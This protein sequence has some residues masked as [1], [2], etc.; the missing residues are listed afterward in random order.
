MCVYTSVSCVLVVLAAISLTHSFPTLDSVGSAEWRPPTSRVLR[1]PKTNS[2]YASAAAHLNKRRVEIHDLEK[3]LMINCTDPHALFFSECWDI[4]GI[5]DYLV[6]QDTGWINTVRYCGTVGD[7]WENDGATCCVKGEA[8][9]TCYLRLASPGSNFDCTSTSGGRCTDAMMSLI[10]V[11]P[12]I[13]PFVRYTV[14][15]IYAINNFFYTYYQALYNS[16][17]VVS[18]NVD[19]MI[20]M[21][22]V[23]VKPAFKMQNVLL[24]LAVGLAF[25]G[26]PSFAVQMID[27]SGMVL[28]ASAQ[29]LV[30][31]A[32]QAPNVGRALW[33]D[34]IDN[35]WEIQTAELHIQLSNIT[36]QM[37]KVIGD[38]VYLLMTD[39]G[40]FASFADYGRYSGPNVTNTGQGTGLTVPS[41][42]ADLAY[43]LKTYLLSYSMWKNKWYA[44]FDLGPYTQEDAGNAACWATKS[45]PECLEGIDTD[46]RENRTFQYWSPYSL[47]IYRLVCDGPDEALTPIKLVEN[48]NAYGWAPLSV[49]FDGAFNCTAEGRAGTNAISYNFDGKLDLACL[50]QLPMYRYPCAAM[51][52]VALVNNTCPFKDIGEVS[53]A[54]KDSAGWM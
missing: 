19:K 52:P 36:D 1:V 18:N 30:I 3:R 25:L 43:G 37:S 51:C 46:N 53:D 7:S 2:V 32:Q 14:K 5:H 22:D 15:N 16:A 54:C 23:I 21:V 26:A 27:I 50:S 48:I 20:Q 28:K 42:T 40:T 45:I 29:A 17:G 49:L 44:T 9:S 8:W 10:K 33:P 39:I 4:L 24:A 6:A 12:S 31:S 13:Y 41:T 11:D 38:A 47:R 34:N 35:S